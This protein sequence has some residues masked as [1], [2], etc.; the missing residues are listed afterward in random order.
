LQRTLERRPD[1]LERA[2]L[3]KADK[4]ILETLKANKIL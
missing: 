3:T 1:L 4:K 2:D